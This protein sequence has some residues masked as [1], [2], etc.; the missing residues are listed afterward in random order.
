MRISDWSSDVCS[1]DL[2]IR[3]VAIRVDKP[4]NY[5]AGQYANVH[6][7]DGSVHRSYS[8]AA[9]PIAG[10]TTEPHFIIRHV[11]GGQFTDRLF[12]GSITGTPLELDGPPGPFLH[13]DGTGPLSG[14]PGCPSP[15]PLTTPLQAAP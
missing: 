8:F 3:R 12:G 11:P 1:S 6:W 7:G 2:D 10:G 9:A 14:Y 15:G 13:G 5:R 4:I